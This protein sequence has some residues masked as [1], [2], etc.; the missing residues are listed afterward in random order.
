MHHQTIITTLFALLALAGCKPAQPLLTQDLSSPVR[1]I[2]RQHIELR[3]GQQL[4][5]PYSKQTGA[6]L[7]VLIRHA[8]KAGGDEDPLL[9][10]E[11][12]RRAILLSEVLRDLPLQA[13]YASNLR[14][15]MLTAEP[16]AQAQNLTAIPYNPKQ[17]D[18]LTAKLQR[19]HQGQTV[20]VVGHSNTTPEL[21]N[22][23]A[24]ADLLPELPESDYDKIFLVELGKGKRRK[25]FQL[26]FELERGNVD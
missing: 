1:A 13:V 6:T 7:F 8:E 10:L 2:T 26:A 16:T 21:A 11:G 9:T 24:G 20:L 23:L 14:R 19:E 4:A 17:L 22:R 15:T 18:E 5:L 12:T 25:V 3:D